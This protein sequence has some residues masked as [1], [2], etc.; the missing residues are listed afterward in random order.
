[1]GIH[2]AVKTR[3]CKCGDKVVIRWS[4]DRE[5]ADSIRKESRA[6]KYVCGQCK[7]KKPSVTDVIKTRVK[8]LLT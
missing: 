1:M 8:E 3:C 6:G 5:L 7:D 2:M 4:S